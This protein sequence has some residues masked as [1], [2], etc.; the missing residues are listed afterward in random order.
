MAYDQGLGLLRPR[1]RPPKHL[2]HFSFVGN[3][4][5][6]LRVKLVRVGR[7]F[8]CDVRLEVILIVAHLT[9]EE[10]FPPLA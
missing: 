10:I 1:R 7:L 8:A 3:V 2:G 5:A 4:I 9:G 6:K